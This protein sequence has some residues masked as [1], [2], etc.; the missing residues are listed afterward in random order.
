[1]LLNSSQACVGYNLVNSRNTILLF[2]EINHLLPFRN[3]TL[4]SIYNL[5]EKPII[6]NM[7]NQTKYLFP[8][9]YKPLL[10]LPD[11]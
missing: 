6:Y 10:E 4:F 2:F 7:L 3:S 9:Q 8:V 11:H 5:N 1:M